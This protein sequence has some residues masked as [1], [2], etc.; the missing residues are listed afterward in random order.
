MEWIDYLRAVADRKEPVDELHGDKPLSEGERNAFLA[1]FSTQ[2]K[3]LS[4]VEAGNAIHRSGKT[5]TTQFQSIY[6]KFTIEPATPEELAKRLR[7][8]FDKLPKEDLGRRQPTQTSPPTPQID[9]RRECK[10]LLDIQKQQLTSSPLQQRQARSLDEVH[11]PLGLVERKEKSLPKFDREQEFSPDKGSE[12]YHQAEPKPIE[13]DAFLVAVRDRQPGQHLVILGEP[14][15]GKTTLLTKVW[16]SLL[17][18]V[19]R[20]A[21][22]IVAW[23][24]LA[25]VGD[26][27]EDYLKQVWLRK[28]CDDEDLATYWESFR[29]L[30]QNGRVWLLLDGADEMGGDALRK[31]ETTLQ[32]NWARSIRAIV[33]CRLNLWD[34]S[35][36]N[37]LNS[38]PSFQIYRTLD[39]KY[40][41]KDM[42]GEFIGKW[43]KDKAEVGKKLRSALDEAGKERIKDLVQNPLR[44]TLLCEI[45]DDKPEL[46]D[47]QA[48]L[49]GKFVD[50]VHKLNAAKFPRINVPK[51]KLDRSMGDLAKRGINKPTLRF[52]FDENELTDVKH[53]KALKALGWLNCVG[54]DEGD[55]DVY[56]F[57]HPTFQEYFAACAI[58]DWD[59]FLPRAHID[60]PV[61]C[62]GETVPTYR[63]FESEWR[64]PI[65]LWFGRG[66]VADEDKEKFIEKLTTFQDGVGDF[67]Y[68]RAYCMAAIGAGEFKSSRKAEMIVQQVVEWAF[69][70]FNTEKQ[71]WQTCP[72]PISFLAKE[73]IPF[74]HC[75]YVIKVLTNP[76]C[77]Y[78]LH[79]NMVEELGQIDPGNPTAIATLI[80][81][82]G[83]IDCEDLLYHNAAI[84]L[85]Q[86]DPGNPTAI[87]TLIKLL[88]DQEYNDLLCYKVARALGQIDLGNQ[89]AI[90]TLI[91]LLKDH[92]Y[93]DL[94]CSAIATLS[95]I[96]VDDQTTITELI[97]LLKDPDCED[98]L[99]DNAARALSQIAVGDQTT[100]TMLINI[101]DSSDRDDLLG[102]AIAILGRI[103]VG[104]KTTITVLT[105]LLKDSNFKDRLHY[106]VAEAL[107]Q[108]E[109]GNST[110]ITAL[111]KLLKDPNFKD[112][113]HVVETL[114]EVAVGSQIAITALINILDKPNCEYRLYV[115]KALGQIDPGNPTAIMALIG[116][117]NDPSYWSIQ[118]CTIPYEL[119]EVAVGSQIAI[120]ALIN[121]LDKPN[122][123]HRHLVAAALG[124][125]DLGNP[126]AIKAL[127]DIL[128]DH[129]CETMLSVNVAE[130]LGQVAIGNPT[131][132]TALINILGGPSDQASFPSMASTLNL[133][134]SKTTMPSA[135]RQIKNNVTDEASK[136]NFDTD[137]PY[138]RV[139]F[140]CAET[141]SYLEFHTTWYQTCLPTL[142]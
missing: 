123:E 70:C 17:E 23:V 38:S 102:S 138:F 63:V 126:T 91:K 130:A 69:G 107:G 118:L 89:T 119:G 77:K 53:Y 99:H 116:T 87:A 35:P 71:V 64:Q 127:I 114:G 8:G 43:F 132:I 7:I 45:W 31:I 108:I 21:D 52:R 3:I 120:T 37:S 136:S 2:Y 92:E 98:R 28:V 137:N 1:V 94:L 140:N 26:R 58:D 128:S 88:K 139:L 109:P 78:L 105:K 104:D 51:T 113:L 47:T 110:A 40:V 141:I 11:V 27:L 16:Q 82:L 72:H 55:Q 106:D 50:R 10:E 24:P 56:A 83:N 85:G 101:L 125:I 96:A 6:N 44:L 74:T 36:M 90:A 33:T 122:C 20:D 54:K 81:I 79:I 22:I 117:L 67:Y 135:I 42:V 62:E 97:K 95:Q 65:G 32:E 142:I 48:Q 39:F 93:D 76:H 12:A 131:A 111:I 84:A 15:A 46:P 57:F 34:A 60:R 25:A 30:R 80:D 73:I 129:N 75:R 59:Y 49:Y 121:I 124:H 86:I 41:P 68:Y 14:G 61:S 19:D 100:I 133:I 112:R 5:L 103:A 134:L 115:A 9:W 29:S 13:H 18:N 66:D 4:F